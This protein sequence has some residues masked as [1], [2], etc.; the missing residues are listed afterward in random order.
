MHLGRDGRWRMRCYLRGTTCKHARLPC[1]TVQCFSDNL[2]A[3]IPLCRTCVYAAAQG[4]HHAL[5]RSW[6]CFSLSI[7]SGTGQDSIFFHKLACKVL[8]TY[9]THNRQFYRY[10]LC[11]RRCYLWWFRDINTHTWR[12][13]IA[14]VHTFVL[15]QAQLGV[16]PHWLMIFITNLKFHPCALKTSL[17]AIR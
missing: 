17:S 6:D 4:E 9:I 5:W 2:W 12:T 16:T 1:H 13:L 8:S 7:Y 3:V 14:R 11:Y 10:I 15:V